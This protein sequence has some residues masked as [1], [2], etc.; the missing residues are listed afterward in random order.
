[1]EQLNNATLE[2]LITLENPRV[3]SHAAFS[4]EGNQ[5]VGVSD[6]GDVLVWRVPSLAEIEAKE[7][8]QRGQ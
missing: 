3:I 4:P 8:A 7:K 6:E 2:Q 1:L 5:L